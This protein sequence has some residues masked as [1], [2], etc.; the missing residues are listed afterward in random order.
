MA[1]EAEGLLDEAEEAVGVTDEVVGLRSVTARRVSASAAARFV[2][3]R[4]ESAHSADSGATSASSTQALRWAR[5]GRHDRGGRSWRWAS[6][7]GEH[8][9][10]ARSAATCAVAYASR[11]RWW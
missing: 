10:A 4:E 3:P 11:R 7:G 9:A 6:P 2:A 5:D 1:G 8:A